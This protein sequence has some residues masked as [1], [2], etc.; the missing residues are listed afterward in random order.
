MKI[1][2]KTLFF[3][4]IIL[5]AFTFIFNLPFNNST[6]DNIEMVEIGYKEKLKNGDTEIMHSF[7]TINNIYTN[8]YYKIGFDGPDDWKSDFG[9][10]EKIIYRTYNKQFGVTF[11]ILVDEFKKNQEKFDNSW[12]LYIENQ[13]KFEN[14][15]KDASERTINSK[16]NSFKVRKGI[17][18]NRISTITTFDFQLKSITENIEFK[19]I[20]HQIYR[21]KNIL[22]FSLVLPIEVYKTDPNT[23][24]HLF[25]NVYFL[26]E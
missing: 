22:T 12:E 17:L 5:I 18:K 24:E 10:G 14:A 13:E 11:S 1:N 15:M 26:D 3:I 9:I 8:S 21:K 7:D 6:G 25:N 4:A 20:T 23:F 16:V 19:S 2:T